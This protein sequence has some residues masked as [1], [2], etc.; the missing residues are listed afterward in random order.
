M[1]PEIVRWIK[2]V[3]LKTVRDR[4]LIYLEVDNLLSA[5]YLGYSQAL[6][7]FNPAL[8]IKF[9]TFAEYRIR[10]AV[11]DEV[12]RE[13]GDERA[14]TKRPI[15]EHEYDLTWTPDPAPDDVEAV[16]DVRFFLETLPIN[17]RGKEILKLR[18]DGFS[19]KEIGLK[20][21]YSESRVSQILNGLKRQIRPFLRESLLLS[22]NGRKNRNGH[23]R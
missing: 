5:G 23:Y 8:N 6:N 14:K 22:S 15:R 17:E 19:M 10:G 13:I 3:V 1:R 12:R 11:L 9:K 18:G 20:L 2:I 16:M 4:G 7:R 21:G